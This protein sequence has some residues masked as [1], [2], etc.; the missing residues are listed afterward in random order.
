MRFSNLAQLKECLTL[1]AV[2]HGYSIKFPTNDKNMLMVVCADGCPWRVWALYMQNEVSF[3][4][5]LYRN[6]H[7]CARKF[8]IKAANAKWLAKVFGLKIIINPKWKLRDFVADVLEKYALDV[9]FS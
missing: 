7:K 4:I 5:K 1:Y 8:K 9:S 3:Q 6:V 2:S